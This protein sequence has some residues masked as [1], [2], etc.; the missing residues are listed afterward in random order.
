MK[1]EPLTKIYFKSNFCML[2]KNKVRFS[3]NDF[4]DK[5][6]SRNLIKIQGF[7]SLI[8]L[9]YFRKNSFRLNA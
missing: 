2:L 1:N 9:K 3:K 5:A 8:Y 6:K 7:K 4:F